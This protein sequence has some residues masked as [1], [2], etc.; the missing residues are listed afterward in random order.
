MR[1]PFVDAGRDRLPITLEHADTFRPQA[2]GKAPVRVLVV[3][4]IPPPF[5][6]QAVMIAKFLE[7]RYERIRLFH[8]RMAF[9]REMDSMGKFQWHK[10]WVLFTTVLGIWWAWL[11]HRPCVLYYPPSGPNMVPV[12]RD[13]ILLI[14]TRWL[15]SKTIFHF[16]AGGLST[17]E[18]QLPGILK[19]LYRLAYR[20]ADLAIRTSA[21]APEDGKALGAKRGA[22][23]WNGV[24]DVAGAPIDR[25]S[26][27][28]PVK[29][30]F[31]ALLGPSKGVE[32]LL[33]SFALLLEKGVQAELRV[34]GKWVD[35]AFERKCM[36]FIE[37]KE[38]RDHVRILGVRTGPDKHL[39]FSS[40]DIFC[41]PSHFEAESFP[42][43][44]M[45]A[46]QYSLPIV[47]TN[48]RGIP[49]MVEEGRTG[50]IVP[51]QDPQA[52]ADKLALLAG[53]PQRRREMGVAARRYYEE[54]FTLTMFQRNMEQAVAGILE[55]DI[56]SKS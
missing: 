1:S 16:H 5:G 54:H 28:G 17:F 15:F 2:K 14:L 12:L 33:R 30:L 25:S 8:V 48:W 19:P 3:G 41:F 45:E 43:V 56:S 46:S 26:A 36:D 39:D 20:N 34:M 6:G 24:D 49:V 32:V 7:G 35:P 42:V 27:S 50:F 55:Q 29:I 51:I 22:I 9:S 21:L 47:A 10:L 23:V 37:Q 52:V 40:S 13:I 4:Q 31:T 44:L 18:Q 11:R 38:M 53:N